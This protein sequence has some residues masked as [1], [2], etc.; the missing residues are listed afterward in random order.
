MTH[1][2]DKYTY[3]KAAFGFDEFRPGQEALIDAILAGRDVLGV[4]PTGAGKSICYELPA[5]MLPGMTL[6]ISPLISLMI[7]QVA[8]LKQAGVPAGYINS[9]LTQSQTVLALARAARG[10]Y[11]VLYVA[12]ERLETNAF[13]D[14]AMAADISMVTVDEAHCVSQWGQ[15]FR[16]SYLRIA[17]FIGNL[18]VRPVV[19]AFTATATPAVKRD[20][21]L[22][23]ELRAPLVM[24]TALDRPNLHFAVFKPQDRDA[25]LVELVLSRAQQSGIVYCGTRKAVDKVCDML[26]DEGLPVAKYHAGM[27]ERARQESQ[28]DFQFDRISVMV[29]TNAFGMGIDKSNVGYVIH[30]NMPRSLEAYYQEAGRAGRDGE[31]ADCILLYSGQDVMLGRYLIEH[32]APNPELTP[33]EQIELKQREYEKL[34][35]M[36]F[37]ATI[38]DCL[39]VFLLNYFGEAAG[40]PCGNC[41]RCQ[42]EEMPELRRAQPVSR[43]ARAPKREKA[44]AKREKAAKPKRVAPCPRAQDA[45]LVALLKKARAEL[46]GAARVPAYVVFSDAS[47]G[48][49]AEKRPRTKAE[50]L[51]LPGVGQYKCDKYAQVF[52]D[53]IAQA[54]PP[55]SEQDQFPPE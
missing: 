7:D 33:I 55:R 42:G 8:A 13:L 52:L 39:R 3:L 28:D 17:A 53:V 36:T 2:Q 32:S 23:L 51:A 18:R 25:L 45:P 6:V 34:K 24:A 44:A 41:S 14:F 48:V 46:A 43:A 16:P 40:A 31:K 49:M 35:Q 21:V 20:I 27:D 10:A 5:L 1:T 11:K 50:F 4:M 38:K 12:P 19:S 29:A 26:A 15:D 9:A 22:G 37:Y 30:Y 54:A 47:L